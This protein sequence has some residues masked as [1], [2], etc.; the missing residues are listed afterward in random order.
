ML[1]QSDVTE[2]D[3]GDRWEWMIRELKGKQ[4]TQQGEVVQALDLRRFKLLLSSLSHFLSHRAP[5]TQPRPQ[6]ETHIRY[7]I[8]H[9]L[10]L[11]S[12]TSHTG[13]S[14]TTAL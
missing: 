11:H 7:S 2:Y 5:V 9:I 13:H 10:F 4:N 1:I 3:E 6:P 14:D 12:H 8:T